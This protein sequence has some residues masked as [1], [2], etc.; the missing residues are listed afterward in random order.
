MKSY[1]QALPHHICE[2]CKIVSVMDGKKRLYLDRTKAATK[3]KFLSI[4]ST[5]KAI[6]LPKR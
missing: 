1:P 2:P 5:G 4:L 6:K 3:K